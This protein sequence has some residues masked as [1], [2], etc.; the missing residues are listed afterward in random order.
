[1]LIEED[2]YYHPYNRSNNREIVFK[3]ERNYPYFLAKYRLYCSG[4]FDTLAYCSMPTHF[5][6]LIQTISGDLEGTRKAVALLLSSYTKALNARWNRHGSLFQPHTKA[7][8]ITDE[9]YLMTVVSCIHQ[10]PV[11]AGLVK[12][13]EDWRH[14]S[15]CDLLD[16]TLDAWQENRLLRNTFSSREVFQQFSEQMLENIRQE[17]WV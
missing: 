2:K 8:E 10:N 17:Y 16:E 14:S 13:M 1:M 3:E 11:R 6:L 4:Y 7:V 15:Y 9:S 5:H 12:R